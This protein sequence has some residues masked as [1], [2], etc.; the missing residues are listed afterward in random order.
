MRIAQG[1]QAKTLRNL[2][3]TKWREGD[4]TSNELE[5]IRPLLGRNQGRDL[6]PGLSDLTLLLAMQ[7]KT[8]SVDKTNICG[9]WGRK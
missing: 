9:S 6:I 3:P 5:P 2:Q 4:F 7:G 1:N 8:I